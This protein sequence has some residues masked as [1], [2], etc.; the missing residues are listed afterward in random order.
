MRMP[1]SEPARLPPAPYEALPPPSPADALARGEDRDAYE[2][3]RR[4]MVAQIR[5]ADVVE[6]VLVGDFCDLVWEAARLRRIRARQ[7]ESLAHLG[8]AQVLG[9]HLPVVGARDLGEGWARRDAAALRRVDE[10]LAKSGLTMEH[11][12][13]RTFALQIDDMERID[14]LIA[15]TET[16][17]ATA[18]REIERHRAALARHLPP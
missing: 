14:R 8:V 4:R 1:L 16:R 15:A 13:A 12:A 3:L 17:R 11:V 2:N 9:P 18:L 7:L 6:E 10:S 5:P